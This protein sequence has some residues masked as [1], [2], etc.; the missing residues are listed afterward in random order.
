VAAEWL[1]RDW[2]MIESNPSY[3]DALSDRLTKGR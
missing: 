3:I 1:Q 2:L